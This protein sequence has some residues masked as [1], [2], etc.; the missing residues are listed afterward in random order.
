MSSPIELWPVS[1]EMISSCSVKG[2]VSWAIPAENVIKIKMTALKLKGDQNNAIKKDSLY[3]IQ[4]NRK[5]LQKYNLEE[6]KLFTYSSIAF[7]LKIKLKQQS[8]G[9]WRAFNDFINK[10]STGSVF[11]IVAA[12]VD[13]TFA[14]LLQ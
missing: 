3:S 11:H 6:L 14:L 12:S 1:F 8:G 9:L 5:V 2:L 10:S 7:I 4:I 13:A